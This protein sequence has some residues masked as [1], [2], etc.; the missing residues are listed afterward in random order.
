MNYTINF[1]SPTA[2]SS[3]RWEKFRS[4]LSWS[5]PGIKV[6]DVYPGQV[7]GG[8]QTQLPV[9]VPGGP[10]PQPGEDRGAGE[11]GGVPQHLRAPR[12]GQGVRH[13]AAEAA[14][15]S[16]VGPLQSGGSGGGE[17]GARVAVLP[18][19]LR[20]L[21]EVR[22]DDKR[23]LSSACRG[24]GPWSW[25][26]SAQRLAPAWGGLGRSGQG[27]GVVA[28]W[29]Q[30]SVL[31]QQRIIH[32]ICC[33]ALEVLLLLFSLYESKDRLRETLLW[34]RTIL[35]WSWSRQGRVLMRRGG[36]NNPRDASVLHSPGDVSSF[37]F[38]CHFLPRRVPFLDSHV[39]RWSEHLRSAPL[40]VTLIDQ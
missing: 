7:G 20:E 12:P 3:V 10:G 28:S 25:L 31:V 34:H 5:V 18:H 38:K 39:N 6:L 22:A 32:F 17:G 9:E 37:L 36:A 21:V 19:P 13:G 8:G 26:G 24:L 23:E 27:S 4:Y 11:G 35:S 40:T 15:E 29:A 33:V 16:C 1:L 30:H 14:G 2:A